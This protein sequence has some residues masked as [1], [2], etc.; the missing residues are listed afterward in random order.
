[1]EKD[2]KEKEKI[3]KETTYIH[4][5]P[6]IHN[7]CNNCGKQ[8]HHFYHCKLPIISIG[9]IAVRWN[10]S[11]N[12][13][14]YLIICRK[15][16]LGFLDFMRGKYNVNNRYYIQNMIEQMTIDEKE[17][18]LTQ[19]FEQLWRNVWGNHNQTLIKYKQEEQISREKFQ[20]LRERIKEKPSD[21]TLRDLIESSKS[22]WTEPEWGFPKGRRNYQECDLDCGIREFIEETGYRIPNIKQH[23]LENILPLEE[24]FMGSNYK[25][26]KHKYYVIVLD[27]GDTMINTINK[28][29]NE[30][31]AVEWKTYE[32]CVQ[33]I[34][35]YNKEKLR[36]LM[37]LRELLG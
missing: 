19:S 15:D 34:R 8:G 9:V 24:T 36:V 22:Q 30:I 28:E 26:Y 14:E 4:P 33:S 29:N 5:S 25:N 31:S 18:L 21:F 32:Q 7:Y 3:E 13:Y 10:P 6:T 1:M 27:Y 35:P 37:N 12:E 17:R 16:T 20:I 2:M 11:N 23:V